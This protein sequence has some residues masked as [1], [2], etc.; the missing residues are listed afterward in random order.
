MNADLDLP[1]KRFKAGM[2]T[3]PQLT[4]LISYCGITGVEFA[5]LL[6]LNAETV[7][8]Y[9]GGRR[10][11]PK[12]VSYAALKLFKKVRDRSELWLRAIE[13]QDPRAVI[14]F[15]MENKTGVAR[16]LRQAALFQVIARLDIEREYE[17]IN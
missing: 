7:Y 8:S 1:N 12:K 13:Q 2:L 4:L 10:G 9:T 6:N 14:T 17:V 5:K 15:D 11:A 16:K 3:G